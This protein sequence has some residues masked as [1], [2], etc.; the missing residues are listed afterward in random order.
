[1]VGKLKG[2]SMAFVMVTL[3]LFIAFGI[4]NVWLLRF[5]KPTAWRGGAATTM[6]QEFSVYGLP[7]WSCPVVGFLKLSAAICLLIGFWI[8]ELVRPAGL[9]IAALMLAA[10]VCH[11]K[12]ADPLRKALPAFGMFILS[13]LVAL[14]TPLN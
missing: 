3:K 14:T 6:P 13:S 12:V 11:I 4:F 5:N 9:I 10:V 8:P 1:M 7:A 2:A